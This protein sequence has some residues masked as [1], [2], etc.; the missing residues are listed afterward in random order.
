MTDQMTKAVQ[1]SYYRRKLPDSCIA[2]CSPKGRKLFREALA[3]GQLECY[4]PLAEQ[5]RTQDEP[6]F[7]GLGTLTNILNAL[8]IDPKKQWK[9]VWRWFH[10]TMLDCCKPIDKVI[11]EGITFS[12]FICLAKCNG[13]KVQS[14]RVN[15]N[16]PC[17]L[18]MFRD[19]L[20]K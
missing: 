12:E 14:R 1:K 17:N 18:K 9:G 19:E 11:D 3:A 2:F 7:C 6:S 5:F 20:K 4:F 13:A 10:E 16:S 15:D 8:N